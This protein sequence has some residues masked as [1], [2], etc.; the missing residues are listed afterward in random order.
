MAA[1]GC[2]WPAT[3]WWVRRQHM[4]RRH[5]PWGQQGRQGPGGGAWSPRLS[6][7][8]RHHAWQRLRSS[9]PS[10]PSF[11]Q[12]I[13]AVWCYQACSRPT[14]DRYSVLKDH[15]LSMYKNLSHVIFHVLARLPD[16][17]RSPH[18]SR[19]GPASHREKWA[20]QS[21]PRF[22]V[23]LFYTVICVIHVTRSYLYTR[24]Q[25]GWIIKQV[26][27]HSI[28]VKSATSGSF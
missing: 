27:S 1:K 10:E 14:T 21:G 4:R 24:N 11:C 6:L 17:L 22:N 16:S 3:T 5:P 7:H 2:N 18:Q 15:L 12:T 23:R 20:R 8:L 26:W 13:T 28:K 19:L 25:P 9:T